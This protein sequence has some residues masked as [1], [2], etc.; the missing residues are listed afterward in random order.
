M[1]FIVIS[2]IL[3]LVLISNVNAFPGRP[4]HVC[5]EGWPDHNCL[6]VEPPNNSIINPLVIIGNI[7]NY[8]VGV[9]SIIYEEEGLI[10][11]FFSWLGL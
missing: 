8:S 3:L 7:T 5:Q 6:R 10:S 1:K 11:K 2:F 4:Y 9:Y